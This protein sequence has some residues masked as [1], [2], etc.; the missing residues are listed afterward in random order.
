MEA[1][2]AHVRK[3]LFLYVCCVCDG[4]F[5]SSQKLVG[6]LKESHAELDQAQALTNCINNSFYLMQPGRATW[7]NEEREDTEERVSQGCRIEQEGED[8]REGEEGSTNAAGAEEWRDGGGENL[9]VAMNRDISEQA[10]SQ[11]EEAEE[12]CVTEGVEGKE[13]ELDKGGAQLLSQDVL[14]RVVPS[15]TQENA[16]AANEEHT[17]SSSGDANSHLSP[18]PPV[19]DGQSLQSEQVESSQ[20]PEEDSCVSQDCLQF[21]TSQTAQLSL[22]HSDVTRYI[23]FKLCF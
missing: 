4:K 8:K 10:T 3:H 20:M 1:L 6:H 17:V 23:L 2:V 22:R 5:V 11:G 15:E 21:I 13:G 14:H 18:A 7:G 9:E 19:E 16:P 12:V